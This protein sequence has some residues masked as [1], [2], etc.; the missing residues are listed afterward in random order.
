MSERSTG[1]SH[2]S[3][4]LL[5]AFDLRSA[6]LVPLSRFIKVHPYAPSSWL[7]KSYLSS[8]FKNQFPICFK[9]VQ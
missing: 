1:L 4:Y 8:I 7:V 2:G 5:I 6:T 9:I 3:L